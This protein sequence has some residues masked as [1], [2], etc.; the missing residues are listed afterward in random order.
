[1]Y[2]YPTYFLSEGCYM[3]VVQDS[4]NSDVSY[5]APGTDEALEFFQINPNTG[6]VSV[7]RSLLDTTS[8]RFRVRA[9]TSHGGFS[10]EVVATVKWLMSHSRGRYL[11]EVIKM[12]IKKFLFITTT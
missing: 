7:K 12:S 1:M 2:V 6:E 4:H 8:K 11:S 5:S 10:Q 3:D 9:Q